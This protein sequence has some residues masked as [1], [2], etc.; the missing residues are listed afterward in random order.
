MRAHIRTYLRGYTISAPAILLSTL[1][2][3]VVLSTE[4]ASAGSEDGVRPLRVATY[5]L[6][7]D[8]PGSGFFKGS[9]YLEDR[10]EMAI[11]E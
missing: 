4:P 3:G 10:L 2:L 11:R 1:V 6:L 5:N 9:T 8:G 7:H